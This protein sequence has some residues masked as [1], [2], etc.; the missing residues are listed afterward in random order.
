[1]NY[2]RFVVDSRRYFWINVYKFKTSAIIIAPQN[3]ANIVWPYR[4]HDVYISFGCIRFMPYKQT[5]HASKS[6][7]QNDNHIVLI[8]LCVQFIYKLYILIFPPSFICKSGHIYIIIRMHFSVSMLFVCKSNHNCEESSWL[9]SKFRVVASGVVFVWNC[10]H[11][12]RKWKT[13][14][15]ESHIFHLNNY[16]VHDGE[17]LDGFLRCTFQFELNRS[18]TSGML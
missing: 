2:T 14:T 10:M 16:D 3:I 4:W 18:E 9:W 12:H 17:S 5:P 13:Y 7:G 1:M 6:H 8:D 15:A 11:A